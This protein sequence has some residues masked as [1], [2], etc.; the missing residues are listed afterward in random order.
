MS[1]QVERIEDL[2]GDRS[3]PRSPEQAEANLGPGGPGIETVQR[4]VLAAVFVVLSGLAL[5]MFGLMATG[6]GARSGAWL[7]LSILLLTSLL[8]LYKNFEIGLVFFVCVCWIAVGTPDLATGGSGGGKR[9]LVSQAGLALLLFVWA[10]RALMQKNFK[11]YYTPLNT[12]IVLFLLV[13]SWS[14]LNSFLFRDPHVLSS[15]VKQFA[16]VNFI[17]LGIRV[18]SLGALLMVANSLR[19]RTLRWAALA[20][21]VPGVVTFTGVVPFLPSSV[22]NAFPQI[23]TMSLLASFVLLGQGKLWLRVGAG[24]LAF[25][26]L[27]FFAARATEWISGWLGAV[28]ALAVISFLAQRRLLWI[29]C[30]LVGVLVLANWGYVYQKVYVN[31]FE[32]SSSHRFDMLR[33]AFLYANHFLLGIGLGNYRSYNLYYGAEWKTTTYTSAHGT[34]AQSLA[35]TGWLGLLALFL[36]LAAG[37]RMLYRY[38][39]ELRPGFPKAYALGAL[40]GFVGIYVSSFAGDYLFPAY[41]NG[42]IATFGSCVYVFLMIGVVTAFAREQQIVW[43]PTPQDAASETPQTAPVYNRGPYRNTGMERPAPAHGRESRS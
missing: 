27:A 6:S 4:R 8:L 19:G 43:R 17:D 21:L 14:T 18:L 29:G 10:T 33:G 5:G 37:T 36:L 32:S 7:I 26:I 20:I 41:H 24:G 42:G 34:Y 40:G 35:E 30:A 15:S 3:P 23:L 31:N 13:S 22:Y 16:A 25:L 28:V 38:Y 39:R 1:G 9:L 11:L 12:P 2:L